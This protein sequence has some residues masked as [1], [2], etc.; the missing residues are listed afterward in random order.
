MRSRTGSARD[1]FRSLLN[2]RHTST[3]LREGCASKL[4]GDGLPYFLILYAQERAVRGRHLVPSCTQPRTSTSLH[5]G[6]DTK[7]YGGCHPDEFPSRNIWRLGGDSGTSTRLYGA[8]TLTMAPE[9]TCR[10]PILFNNVGPG[11]LVTNHAQGGNETT[12]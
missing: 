2:S 12:S 4:Y 9:A 3:S 7:L 11:C 1:A 6:H 5:G 8:A 10:K